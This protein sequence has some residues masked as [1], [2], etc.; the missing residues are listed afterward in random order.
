MCT[1]ISCIAMCIHARDTFFTH[2]TYV[3][4]ISEISSLHIRI[5]SLHIRDML[6]TYN[7]YAP[8]V[9]WLQLVGALKSQVSFAEYHLLYRALL[10]K[11][12]TILRSLLI[13][14]TPYVYTYGYTYNKNYTYKNYAL[15]IYSTRISLIC[16]RIARVHITHKYLHITYICIMYAS[17]MTIQNAQSYHTVVML[18]VQSYH[19]GWLLWGG[20]GQ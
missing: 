12:S 4:Y 20:H 5:C 10:H 15:C 6:F 8:P 3:L 19:V 11:R 18:Y 1:R 16:I 2:N 17:C 14:A 7:R 13:V 9:G